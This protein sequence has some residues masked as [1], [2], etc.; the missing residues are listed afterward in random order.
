MAKEDKKVTWSA[1]EYEHNEKRPDWF[2]ALGIIAISATIASIIY[3]NY[4]FAIFII[5]GTFLM[6]YF[7]IRKPKTIELEINQEGIRVED[8][9]YLYEKIKSYWIDRNHETPKLLIH[10]ERAFM[11]IITIPLENVSEE[12][13]IEILDKHVRREEIQEPFAHKIM[14]FLGF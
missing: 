13:V 14:D 8:E 9:L 6:A 1:P 7:S 5:L 3:K 4:L 10:S 12:D 2:W 11:P